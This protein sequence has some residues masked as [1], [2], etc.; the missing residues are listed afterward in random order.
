MLLKEKERYGK[1]TSTPSS[2]EATATHMPTRVVL[3]LWWNPVDG[4]SLCSDD[5]NP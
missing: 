5:H 1:K 3:A 4:V 2:N